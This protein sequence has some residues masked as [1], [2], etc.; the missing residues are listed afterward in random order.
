MASTLKLLLRGLLAITACG[1]VAWLLH[2]C[3]HGAARLERP[4]ATSPGAPPVQRA[5][6][7]CRTFARAS[8]NCA[9]G[10]GDCFNPGA[11]PGAMCNGSSPG[12]FCPSDQPPAGASMAF[13][14]MDWT[15]G[16]GAQRAAEAAYNERSGKS[17]VYFG[18][19]TYG[20]SSD[21]Q[22]GLGM[23]VQMDVEG[24]DR[25]ILAQSIN[26]GSDVSGNQF[27]LQIG[28]GGAGIFNTC[29][30]G[31]TSMYEGQWR[32]DLQ[33]G[34]GVEAQSDGSRY[35]GTFRAGCRAGWGVHF[36]PD[37]S[38]YRGSWGDNDIN[39][40]GIYIGSDGRRFLGGWVDS[41]MHGVGSYS[42]QDGRSYCGQFVQDRRDGFGV[43]RWP[44]GRRH[45]GYWSK[46]ERCGGSM[47][48]P[49]AER[50]KLADAK[51]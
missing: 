47:I 36:W 25:P 20:T 21:P 9:K 19:G 18:V 50:G 17:P 31:S 37:G 7:D 11:R 12:Y 49:S 33:D 14:C 2:S 5:K 44:D 39:G 27:D 32:R 48:K 3:S 38:E 51:A 22:R 10:C 29:A 26:T 30:G 23:C 35:E 41:L 45:E 28:A 16:S 8:D 42:W 6:G 43:F 13:A 40:L 15:F 4:P 1:S 24:V 46:G 34:H